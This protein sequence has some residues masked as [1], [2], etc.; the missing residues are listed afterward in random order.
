MDVACDEKPLPRSDDVSSD[1]GSRLDPEL[2]SARID[3]SLDGSGQVRRLPEEEQV[4]AHDPRDP[5]S[6]TAEECV[7]VHAPI[8]VD[9]LRAREEV[10]H[11]PVNDR[12]LPEEQ[13]DVLALLS[14]RDA[15]GLG[16]IV[17]FTRGRSLLGACGGN[18]EN[19][20]GVQNARGDEEERAT[21]DT[22]QQQGPER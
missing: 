1:R 9:V 15:R 8:Q 10:G 13:R 17:R 3:V 20:G 22:D 14:Q 11:H 19:S 16:G 5:R 12:G 6:L 4:T 18:D 21:D 7:V 2:L